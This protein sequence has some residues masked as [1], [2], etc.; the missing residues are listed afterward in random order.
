MN[1]VRPGGPMMVAD[2]NQTLLQ[3]RA[4]EAQ[5]EMASVKLA[6]DVRLQKSTQA[7]NFVS[8]RF[9]QSKEA[10]V[11]NPPVETTEETAA[12]AAAFRWLTGFFGIDT[13]LEAGQ[14]LVEQP[15]GEFATA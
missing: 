2:P 9:I 15:Q 13:P 3:S 8:M 4:L 1:G 11:L 12:R 10:N 5:M 7:I 14:P 6:Q